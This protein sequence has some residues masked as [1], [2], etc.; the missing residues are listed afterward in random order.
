MNYMFLLC[1]YHTHSQTHHTICNF[2]AK[3]CVLLENTMFENYSSFEQSY[4]SVDSQLFRQASLSMSK[5][6]LIFHS[7]SQLA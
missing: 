2:W 4:Y 3:R 5:I 1:L 7:T 6:C